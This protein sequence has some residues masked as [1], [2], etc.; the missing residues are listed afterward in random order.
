MARAVKAS[1]KYRSPVREE[2]AE[3]TR[4][5][6]LDAAHRLFLKHGYAGTTIAAVAAEADVSPE[7][8]Y[9][10]LGGKRG[11]LEGVIESTVQGPDA[12]VPFERQTAYEQ[13]ASFATPAERLRALVEFACG[14]L[15]RTS[16]V[17]AVIRGAADR[18]PFAV[19]LRERQLEER[20]GRIALR[21]RADLTE[22]LR[23]GLTVEQAAQR[24]GALI[25][26][27]L[28]HLLTVQLGW[29]PDHFREWVSALAESD[30]LGSE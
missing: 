6:V 24:L 13:I 29:K 16:P 27:E 17:H 10:S 8:I 4:R 3:N 11:L 23:P 28:Y 12:S 26:P 18:E 25:S 19:D 21:V 30:L 14:I 7:T 1:R 5:R 20:L 22:A 9:G 15:A 2:Q